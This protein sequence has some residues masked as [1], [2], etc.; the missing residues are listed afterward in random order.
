M[1]TAYTVLPLFIRDNS[2]LI[3]NSNQAMTLQKRYFYVIFFSNSGFVQFNE[4][5]P[6]FLFH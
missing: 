4:T 5:K 6:L 1:I 2:Q 3:T